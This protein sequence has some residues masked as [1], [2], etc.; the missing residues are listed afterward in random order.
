MTDSVV[1][2]RCAPSLCLAKQ[3]A[4]NGVWTDYNQARTFDAGTATLCSLDD[5][6]HCLAVA[7]D[8]PRWCAIRGALIDRDKATGIRRL[9]RD[10]PRTGDKATVRDVARR[11]VMLDVDAVPLPTGVDPRD[12]VACARV[13]VSVLPEP[14]RGARCI[15][16]PSSGHAI[17]QGVRAHLW[18]WLDRPLTCAQLKA[19]LQREHAP[20]DMSVYSPCQP[21]YTARPIFRNGTT[22]PLPARLAWLDGESCVAV[23]DLRD[24]SPATRS[25]DTTSA[26]VDGG[27]PLDHRLVG[28]MRKLMHTPHG[29]R[30]RMIFWTAARLGE[31]VETGQMTEDYAIGWI[32][33]V[34]EAAEFPNPMHIEKTARDGVSSGREIGHPVIEFEVMNDD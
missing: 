23:P 34:C 27:A 3:Y 9:L 32:C 5:L 33:K 10:D 4:G 11:W 28:L 18:Y 22:D 8:D 21:H 16:Q 6:Y 30:H 19:W 13:A 12:L 2:L 1:F 24:L 20:V 29:S 26:S 25:T 17:K 15:V 14:F 31:L 7:A